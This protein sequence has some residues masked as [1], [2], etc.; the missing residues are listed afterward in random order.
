MALR[1]PEDFKEFLKLLN[2]H[3]VEYLIV[4]GYAVGF[5]GYA[6]ATADMDVWVGVSP[7]NAGRVAAALCDFGFGPESVSPDLFLVEDRIVRLGV[8]PLRL[9]I[10]TT[11]SGVS[12]VDCYS[13]RTRAA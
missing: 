3:G 2:S 7:Q 10:L 9:E 5:Y 8:P 4:G 11:I 13:H 12:F 6:R 1:L